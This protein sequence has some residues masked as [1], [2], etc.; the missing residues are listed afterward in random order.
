MAVFKKSAVRILSAGLAFLPLAAGAQGDFFKTIDGSSNFFVVPT[1]FGGEGPAG[2]GRFGDLVAVIINV[3]L[4]AI[5]SVAVIF[6]IVG[7]YRYI[8]AHGNEEKSEAAKKTMTAA[9]W[10]L[11][12]VILAAAIITI[13][14]RILIQGK[15]GL[16]V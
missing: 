15:G 16:G 13:I 8:T 7:A 12:I 10:G 2:K 9:I 14:S 3:A 1:P 6:L 11:I 5:A 4:L